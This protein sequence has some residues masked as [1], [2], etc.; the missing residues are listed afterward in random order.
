MSLRRVTPLVHPAS[1]LRGR[2]QLAP[3]QVAHL[4]RLVQGGDHFDITQPPPCYNAEPTLE[5]LRIFTA[6]V[7]A[8]EE[9]V[10]LDV[11]NAGPHLVCCGVLRLQPDTLAPDR[12][13][14]WRFRR[15]GGAPWWDAW[16]DHLQAVTLLD[17]I[18]GDRRVMKVGHFV[19]Q[20]DF[21]LLLE[22]GF[23]LDGPLLD[24]SALCH[25]V[26]SELPKGLQ[27]LATAFCGAPR[28][29]DIPDEKDA[30]ERPEA[31]EDDA[32]G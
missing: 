11:E 3:V 5:E 13:V 17:R 12:G 4:R 30:E 24:T 26:H 1:I 29:K 7:C 19:I 10:V 22:L 14:C 27:F 21:P 20:H 31:A 8:D 6:L 18:L 23:A 16:E 25:A 2:P 15:Q 32:A 9:R 28:W